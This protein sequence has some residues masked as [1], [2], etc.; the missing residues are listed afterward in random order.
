MSEIQIP[1][2]KNTMLNIVLHNILMRKQ[3]SMYALT[4]A[5]A[6]EWERWILLWTFHDTDKITLITG[7]I[8]ETW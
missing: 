3:C 6:Q 1:V 4:L 8:Y 2:Y 7:L 5:V